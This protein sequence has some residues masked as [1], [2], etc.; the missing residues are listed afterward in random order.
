[1][2]FQK[3]NVQEKLNIL[4]LIDFRSLSPHEECT[5]RVEVVRTFDDISAAV[6]GGVLNT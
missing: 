2:K 4:Y 6:L 1:M 3:I 5:I